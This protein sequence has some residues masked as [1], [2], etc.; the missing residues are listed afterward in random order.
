MKLSPVPS[1]MNNVAILTY[2]HEGLTFMFTY[3]DEVHLGLD[4]IDT[5]PNT[6]AKV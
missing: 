1:I 2:A 6:L 3:P 4:M 5:K